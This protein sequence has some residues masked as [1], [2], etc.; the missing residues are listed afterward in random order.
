MKNIIALPLF[1]LFSLSM[2]ALSPVIEATFGQ[3][4]AGLP[5]KAEVAVGIIHNGE[6][7]RYGYTRENGQV[8]E[9]DHENAIFEIGSITKTFTAT[10]LMEQVEKGEME[11]DDPIQ[12][13][14]PVSMKQPDYE[15][16]S[17]T[18]KHLATHTSGLNPAPGSFLW[19]YLKSKLFA[20]R[21]PY[22]YMKAKHYYRYLKGFKLDYIPGQEWA[23]NNA[24]V[25]LL[26]DLVARHQQSTWEELVREKLFEPLGMNDSYFRIGEA[27][28]S[29]MVQGYNG[30][31][32]KNALW[33]M[34]FIN[35]AGV[36][37]STPGDMMKW[38]KAHLGP[39]A[40]LEYFT[41][42]HRNLDIDIPPL[43]GHAMGIGWVHKIVDD[44]TRFLWHNGGTGGFHSF[45]GFDKAAP[46]GVFIL[47]NFSQ[48]HPKMKNDAG[49]SKVDALG[50]E[51]L[52][53]LKRVES[54]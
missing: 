24:A 35:P 21:N 43:E 9:T 5:D 8:R 10:L 29:R 7:Y 45:L 16:H 17:I 15:G 4:L 38:L 51:L 37:K 1:S 25:A 40:E 26:G 18:L 46:N 3:F 2:T 54:R 6:E 44:D 50:F 20:P 53:L 28:E 30:K 23:Y 39:P 32:K 36:I 34:D 19:P 12:T 33:E 14:L 49:K 22:K 11:L 27:Q 47:T 42:T 31:G 13:Y 41:A 52:V 48:S